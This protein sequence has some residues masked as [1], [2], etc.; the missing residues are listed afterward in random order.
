MAAPVLDERRK[1]VLRSLIQLHVE[2]G[3]PVGSESLARALHRSLSPATLRNIMADLEALGYLDHPHTSA[4]P[5]AH[6][7]GLSGLRGQPD[8]PPR[9]RPR[10]R[11]GHPLRAPPP[12]RVRGPGDGATPPTSSPASPVNVGFVLAPDIAR[13]S[14]R[15]LDL[16][17][18]AHPRVLVVMVSATGIVTNKVI[19]VEEKLSPEE[20]QACANYLNAHFA[21]QTL[22]AIRARLLD[23]MKEEKALYDSLLKKVVALGERAFAV[24]EGEASVYLD[25]TSN[26]LRHADFEDVDRMR[27]LFR[28]FEEKSRLVKILNACLSGEGH[29]HP[30]R[31]REPG[32]R[33]PRPGARHGA[34]PRGG[35]GGLGPGRPGLHAHGVRA[36]GRA[37]R[38]RGTRGFRR[39]PGA[40]VLTDKRRHRH[41]DEATPAA[42]DDTQAPAPAEAPP[43]ADAP[44]AAPSEGGL[45]AVEEPLTREAVAL[46]RQERD[47]LRD[48]LL[49]K[50]AEFEN[51]RKRVE[52]DRQQAAFG[53]HGRDLQ[54]AHPH[55]RQPRPSALKARG[56]ADALRKG[57]ELTRR[58]LLGAPREPGDRG[59]RPH[60]RPLRS[61]EPPGPVP[62]GGPRAS[63]TA[64][65]SRFSARATGSRTGCCV[66][67]SSRSRRRP[68]R[69]A[70][71]RRTVYTEQVLHSADER[72]QRGHAWVR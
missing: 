14:F 18:L 63:P 25:G 22:A 32:P 17:R 30:H 26:I 64:P 29:P 71:T 58:E 16:V 43:A 15:H 35:R 45:D 38:P 70:R 31:P 42:V 36:R 37:R 19:E 51:Y 50:R 49:R 41:H 44:A 60:G 68:T 72:G 23:L 67:P 53:R 3:E 13:T 21:G 65:S 34:L 20:L 9:P 40:Q 24:P 46:L 28:T 62:R 55:P 7:R 61:R 39:P 56:D 52:R 59:R 2:T 10:R 47:E 11:R 27:A 66:P 12:R 33:P 54:G 57:V 48:Q 6:R 69:R 5:G 1:E 4:G 8:A